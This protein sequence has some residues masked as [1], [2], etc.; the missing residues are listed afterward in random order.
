MIDVYDFNVVFQDCAHPIL[1][2]AVTD[3]LADLIYWEQNEHAV[4][5]GEGLES[6]MLISSKWGDI[7]SEKF[8]KHFQER[9]L[10]AGLDEC[11]LIILI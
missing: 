1:G 6:L 10:Q 7:L 3:D 8:D 4:D 2:D 5:A 11:G 9:C